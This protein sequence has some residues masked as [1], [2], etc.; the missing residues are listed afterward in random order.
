MLV[1]RVIAFLLIVSLGRAAEP[2]KP[3]CVAANESGQDLRRAGKLREAREKFASCVVTSCPPA[4]RDDCAERLR[5]IEKASASV[6]FEVKDARGNDLSTVNVTVDGQPLTTKLDG[7]AL[8]VDL[9]EHT[10]RF[11]GEGKF[12]EEKLVIREG[13]KNRRERIVLGPTRAESP[14]A[15]TPSRVPAIVAFAVG[16]VGLVVGLVFMGVW[17]GDP[18]ATGNTCTMA[19]RNDHEGKLKGFSAGM[20][21]GFTV[22]GIGSAVGTIL[23]FT[24]AGPPTKS[25]IGARLRIGLGSLGVEGRFW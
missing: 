22:A 24:S 4:V 3:E 19:D 2:A 9:G 5:E 8:D 20:G 13:E 10:F 16:G 11:E 18:C 6:V 17:L 23:L 1:A 12:L 25:A 21:I 14:R 15:E 7:S